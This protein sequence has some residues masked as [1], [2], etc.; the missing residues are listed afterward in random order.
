M[1]T[2]LFSPLQLGPTL[3]RNRIVMA[4]LTR[5]RAGT[6]EAPTPLM[7]RYYAQRASAGLI[8]TEATQVSGFGIPYPNTPGLLSPGQVSGWHR[9]VEAVHARG[10]AIFVQLWYGGR[11]S[12]PSLLPNN[13]LP[14]APSAIAPEGMT[15]TPT[16][17]QPF[18]TPRELDTQ[19]VGDIVEQFRE[20]AENAQVAG[21]DGIEI[22]AANGYLIDQFLRDGSN[23][24]TDRY[25]G[26]L[27]NRTRFLLEV[28]EEVIGT[29]EPERVGVR[30]SPINTFN[31]M[32]DS[33]PETLFCH[34][35][36]AL[37]GYGLA[38]L[39]VKEDGMPGGPEQHVDYQRL[40]RAWNGV[41]MV[42]GGYD[43]ARAQQ[44]IAE[45]YADLV[46]FGRAFISNPDLPERLARDAPLTE[47]DPSTFYGGDEHGYTDYPTL[48]EQEAKTAS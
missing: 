8:I 13:E 42:N 17:L 35:A 18:V 5:N 33:D 32:Y 9:V 24:R 34:V 12:H 31:S 23:K 40:R 39:H 48:A 22:H 44:V 28:V 30:I 26:S 20:A 19:E 10:G 3:L 29:W 47:P 41:Y 2:D 25:G 37:S 38:Y 1:T 46:A 14:V 16:G 4:P 11:I 36:E 43:K 21:F 45:G 6:A 15:P 27:E 7:T